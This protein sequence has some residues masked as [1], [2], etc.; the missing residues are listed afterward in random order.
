MARF[1]NL[2]SLLPYDES[3]ASPSAAL[4]CQT[5]CIC[6]CPTWIPSSRLEDVARDG[7]SRDCARGV[8]LHSSALQTATHHLL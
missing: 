3:P 1:S 6:Q 7:C 2:R 4:L 8:R 5:L